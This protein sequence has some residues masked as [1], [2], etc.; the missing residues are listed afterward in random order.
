M[1]RVMMGIQTTAGVEATWRCQTCTYSD[2]GDR[3]NAG[4]YITFHRPLCTTQSARTLAVPRISTLP[5]S[6]C[7]WWCWVI[8]CGCSSSPVICTMW[9]MFSHV[10]HVGHHWHHVNWCHAVSHLAVRHL[11]AMEPPFL[12]YQNPVD[13]SAVF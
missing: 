7:H 3:G 8:Y 6:P 12:F 1:G 9:R 2:S 4:I 5:L 11:A 10:L 13:V